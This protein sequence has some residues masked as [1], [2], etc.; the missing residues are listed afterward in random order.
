MLTASPR[1]REA[2]TRLPRRQ[3]YQ[4]KGHLRLPMP[5]HS[6][7]VFLKTAATAGLTLA[8]GR[9]RILGANDDIRLA[10]V[11]L[12]NKGGSHVNHISK[13]SGARIA[14][15]C[16]V[17]PKR[18]AAQRAKLAAPAESVF[19]VDDPRHILD[20]KDID[21][22]VIATP[23][24][25]HALLA[26]WACQAGKD[27]YVEKPVSHNVREG[28]QIIRAAAKYS[29]IVQA[30]TQYRSDEGLLE[31]ADYVRKG[32]LGR[33]LWGHVIWYELRQSIG[34]AEPHRPD[35]LDYDLYCGPAPLE[36][37]TRPRL[38]YDWHWVWSTG[39]GDLANSG[40][41]ALDVCRMIA[42]VEGLPPN[43]YC[44]GGRFT[45][46]DAGQTPN[47]QL[48][49]LDYPRIPVLVENRN[50][51]SMKGRNAMDH[52][53][54]IRE[55]IV[56]QCE[57]GYIAGM[58]GGV[59]AYDNDSKKVKEF[60]GDAG[61]GHAANFLAAVRSRNASD[62]HA[63]MEGGHVSSAAC[64]LGNISY[65]LGAGA[66]PAAAGTV[67]KDLKLAAETLTRLEQHLAANEV[68]LAKTPMQLGRWLR[69]DERSEE[70]TSVDGPD[71][72][73]ALQSAR[74]MAR[75]QYRPPF[76]L[77]EI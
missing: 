28:R 58:R 46:D 4:L 42:G 1:T 44:L 55:G 11:G 9:S 12:G 38:H 51:P 37:L 50:L 54:G 67:F 15:L 21:A 69:V 35:D 65:R 76:V 75:G 48:T 71:A 56:L 63:P 68:D 6:R 60:P 20:R 41:H 32:N 34:R 43:V 62:L 22:V 61:S 2:D 72:D 27:V 45:F 36:P 57:N 10:I 14:A 40:I 3:A 64:H 53:R 39:D 66:P 29:R 31:A 70:I 25:W 26:V 59:N 5:F 49:V 33:V 74:S 77:P 16:D 19:C 30:G 7:R 13:L 24:H 8:G 47:T 17:D 18:L 23:N 73:K 52:L